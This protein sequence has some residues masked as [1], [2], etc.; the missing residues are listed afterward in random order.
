MNNQ[1][2]Q[3]IIGQSLNITY[4][5]PEVLV[6]ALKSCILLLRFRF[7]GNQH[8]EEEEKFWFFF[9][10]RYLTTL[11]TQYKLVTEHAKNEMFS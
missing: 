1:I 2:N 9:L 7:H 6:N 4:Y 11:R 3:T 8:P 5:V 10:P